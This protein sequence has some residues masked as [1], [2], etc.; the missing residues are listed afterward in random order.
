MPPKYLIR[1]SKDDRSVVFA[2]QAKRLGVRPLGELSASA[3]GESLTGVHV[4]N[5]TITTTA[6]GVFY[7]MKIIP[8]EYKMHW[9]WP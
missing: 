5:E 9:R 3:A 1:R 4:I 6:D 2:R 7:A 8:F